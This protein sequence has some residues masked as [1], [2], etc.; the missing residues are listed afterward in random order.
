MVGIGIT[1][2]HMSR[3]SFSKKLYT[4]T[5]W[6][7]QILS[8]SSTYCSKPTG[9]RRRC[10]YGGTTGN[11]P[12]PSG[13]IFKGVGDVVGDLSMWLIYGVCA[14]G[15]VGNVEDGVEILVM[16]IGSRG[17]LSSELMGAILSCLET[18]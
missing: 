16:V 14:G 12:S 10:G 3:W 4:R 5:I 1:R 8:G 13:S 15:F 17:Q 2:S 9:R 6:T 11:D 7:G 18:W